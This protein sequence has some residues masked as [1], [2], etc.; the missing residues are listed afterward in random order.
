MVAGAV[1]PI[2][3]GH[4]IGGL[5]GCAHGPATIIAPANHCLLKIR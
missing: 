5:A 1:P 4:R 3:V 2:E